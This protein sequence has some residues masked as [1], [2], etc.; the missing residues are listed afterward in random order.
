MLG[1]GFKIKGIYLVL[2]NKCFIG[3][4]VFMMIL[5][6]RPFIQFVFD[7]YAYISLRFAFGLFRPLPYLFRL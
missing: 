1:F 7:N 4:G 3:I 6:F 5:N 2:K